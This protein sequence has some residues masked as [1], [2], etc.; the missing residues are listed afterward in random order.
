MV[1]LIFLKFLDVE[2]LCFDFKGQLLIGLIAL[3]VLCIYVAVGLSV[4]IKFIST[5]TVG[6]TIRA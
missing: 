2:T 1:D 4:I 5:I 3:I 6:C